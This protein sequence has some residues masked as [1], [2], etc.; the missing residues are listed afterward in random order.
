MCLVN[1]M[2]VEESQWALCRT[3]ACRVIANIVHHVNA[4]IDSIFEA[5]IGM[6]DMTLFHANG[7]KKRFG[8]EDKKRFLAETVQD[9]K[10]GTGG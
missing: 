9:N 4:N 8:T 3:S 1:P 7:A 6:Q 2:E 10:A 5:E